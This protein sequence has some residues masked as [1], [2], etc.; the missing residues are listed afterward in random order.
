MFPFPQSLNIVN[1]AMSDT[2]DISKCSRQEL[3]DLIWS[4]P[5]TKLA[6]DFGISDVAIAKRCKRLSVPRPPPG[7]WAKVAAGQKPRKSPL[8]PLPPTPD[9]AFKQAAQS[10][11]L[12]SLP[13][14]PDNEPLLPLA[15]ELLSAI[16]KAKLD[17]YKRARLENLTSLPAVTVSKNLAQRVA[18]AFHILLS[19]LEPIG[20][21]FRKYQ[22]LY[23]SGYFKRRHDRL[24]VSIT[25]DVVRPDGSRVSAPF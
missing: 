13:L 7:Y 2:R 18:R 8:P 22:G 15:A 3:Y 4:T 14:P 9:E 17:D 20:I 16:N 5:A 1:A 11:I 12:K 19:E 25:E 6:P 21:C 24:Y 23:D 10:R